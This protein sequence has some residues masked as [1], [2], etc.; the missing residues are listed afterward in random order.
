MLLP[1]QGVL[2]RLGATL[3]GSRFVSSPLGGGAERSEAKG[4]IKAWPPTVKPPSP[5]SEG[6]LI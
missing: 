5:D 6:S 2:S 4:A 3:A 1:P